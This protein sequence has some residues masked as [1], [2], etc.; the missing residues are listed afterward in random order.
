MLDKRQIAPVETGEV[1]GRLDVRS[2]RRGQLPD[3][4]RVVASCKTS[5]SQLIE[6]KCERR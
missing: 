1:N 5:H 4:H 6:R 2:R 3:L